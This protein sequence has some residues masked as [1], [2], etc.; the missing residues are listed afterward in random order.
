M[1]T[2]SFIQHLLKNVSLDSDR[3]LELVES[4]CDHNTEDLMRI[5]SYLSGYVN[6]PEVPQ[7]SEIRD[8]ATLTSYDFF[9]DEVR[10]KYLESREFKVAEEH[11]DYDGKVFGDW[12]DIPSDVRNSFGDTKITVKYWSTNT[13]HLDTWLK[14]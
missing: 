10:Y 5:M 7:T 6:L 8:S 9:K 4:M 3:V 12:Y 1:Q 14:K 2:N 11:K 13:C